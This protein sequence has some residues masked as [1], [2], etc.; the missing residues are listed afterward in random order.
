VAAF[1][2]IPLFDVRS[3]IAAA[4]RLPAPSRVIDRPIRKW[5]DSCDLPVGRGDLGPG[6]C[7]PLLRAQDE[8]DLIVP[9]RFYSHQQARFGDG[10][11][12][13]SIS[14]FIPASN[15]DLFDCQH[16]GE[17]IP[18]LAKAAKK[19]GPITDVPASL[20]RIWR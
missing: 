8:L 2:A 16:W 11:V 10:H 13:A 14:R 5:Q 12:Y 18:R 1:S 4:V 17:R 19:S 15:R 20:L 6:N 9:Q 7:G 3:A